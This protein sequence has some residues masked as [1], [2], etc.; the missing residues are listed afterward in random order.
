MGVS[1]A[2]VVSASTSVEVEVRGV[3]SA[4]P[5]PHP[6]PGSDSS[7]ERD[8]TQIQLPAPSVTEDEVKVQWEP[9]GETAVYRFLNQQGELVLQVPSQQMLNLAVDIAQELDQNAAPEQARGSTGG[10]NHG[11]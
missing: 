4:Q 11:H 10:N 8:D 2:L 1:P 9:P 6:L 7:G 3:R 5:A